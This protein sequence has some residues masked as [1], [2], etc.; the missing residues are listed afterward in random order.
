[1]LRELHIRNLAVLAG[2]SVRF[3]PGLNTLTGETGA[4]KSI[5]V[6]SLMLL[7]GGRAS[8]DLIRTGADRLIVSGIFDPA[9]QGWRKL[10][11]DAGVALEDAEEYPTDRD[12]ATKAPPELLVRREISRNGRNRVFV[13]DQPTTLKLLNDLAPFLLRIHGQR[14]E[15]ALLE[16]DL[17]RKWL[18][19]SGGEE[20]EALLRSVADAYAEV[21]ELRQRLARVTGDQRLRWER[22]DLLRFQISEIDAAR[23]EAGE[24]DAL[25][26]ERD[27]LRNG[28]AIRHAL[29]GSVDLLFDDDGAAA[30]R[31]ARAGAL[32]EEVSSWLPGAGEWKTELAELRIRAEELASTLREHLE[33]WD[34]DPGRLDTIEARLATL[35]RL[36]RK[37]G[38]S[39]EEI[40]ELRQGLGDELEELE[41]DSESVAELETRLQ[42]ILDTYRRKALKLSTAR[43]RLGQALCKAMARQLGDLGLGKARLE[44]DLGRRR[45]QDSSLTVD[46]EAIDFG[47]AGIDQVV[48]RFS[49]NPG[50]EAQPLSRIASGGEL[51]R[52]S[53]ALQLA[54]GNAGVSGRPTM[55]FD[56]VDTGVGGAEAAAIGLKLHRLARAGQILAVTHLPQVASCGD[57]QFKVSKTVKVSKADKTKRTYAEVT[58]LDAEDRVKEIARML[59]GQ[60]VTATS[61]SHA[62]ELL[63]SAEGPSD[64]A[65]ATVETAVS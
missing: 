45:R 2:A 61:I 43:V 9:G 64:E 10:L 16:S 4:G 1:M 20:A 38:S 29:G 58:P 26:A 60:E 36:F 15:A 31:L 3:G 19:H 48:F 39:S 34:A 40:L 11:D 22:I 7:A 42:K 63:A 5:V 49:P 53:L 37:H 12:Q 44:V 6:D 52:L 56:E 54:A 13:N 41:G 18:D 25:R 59:A 50:E 28:E 8:S 24:E 51:S 62:R 46:G 14:D 57:A 47:P 23:L 17:Q 30:E 55:V 32:L 21:E 27:R 33:G 65:S 35:E